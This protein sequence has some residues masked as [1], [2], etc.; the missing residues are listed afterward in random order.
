MKTIGL[1]GG[2]SWESSAE[3]YKIINEEIYRR[4]GG[5]HSAD[6]IMHSLDFEEVNKAQR[7][8]DWEEATA[9]IGNAIHGVNKAGADIILIC[10]VTGHQGYEEL[11]KLHIPILHVADC[12]NPK[13][14]NMKKVALLGTIHTMEMDYF[15]SKLKTEVIIPE[16]VDREFVNSIIY[17]EISQG[18]LLLSSRNRL[19][20]IIDV[21]ARHGAEGVIL[22][23]TELP[24][25]ITEAS[26]PQIS[27]TKVHALAA[28]DKALEVDEKNIIDIGNEDDE[29]EQENIDEKNN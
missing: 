17:N 9:L 16:K 19:N 23:C 7:T 6:I 5:L 1:I 22:G 24:L 25:L 20:R 21:L 15:K 2:M 4:L 14:E 27:S 28:V 10:S 18:R 12:I 8:G 3:Y 26:I 13:I 29:E 11:E